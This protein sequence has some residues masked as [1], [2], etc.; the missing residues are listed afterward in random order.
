MGNTLKTWCFTFK[1][2]RRII[3]LVGMTLLVVAVLGKSTAKSVDVETSVEPVKIIDTQDAEAFRRLTPVKF[4]DKQEAICT[5]IYYGE[6]ELLAL[7]IQA[8]AGNQDELGKRYVADVIMNRVHSK[9]FPDTIREVLYQK[10]PVQF[11]CV[12]DGALDKAGYTVTEDCFTIAEEEYWSQQ[13]TEIVYFRTQKYHSS[14]HPKFKH[15]DH[16]FSTK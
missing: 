3:V 9:A 12:Y 16:Y 7:V 2:K 14:G 13:D 4:E 11:A 10:N 5:E 1:S 6:L 15:G 8:E